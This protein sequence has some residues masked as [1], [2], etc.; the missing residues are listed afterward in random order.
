MAKSTNVTFKF[1][2]SA[3]GRQPGDLVEVSDKGQIA[4]LD[5]FR[6]AIRVGT[7]KSDRQDKPEVLP[8]ITEPGADADFDRALLATTADDDDA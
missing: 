4:F 7:A 2:T 3:L 1:L 8:A 5:S 6:Y